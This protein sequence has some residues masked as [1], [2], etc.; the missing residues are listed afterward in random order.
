MKQFSSSWFSGPL[1]TAVIKTSSKEQEGS[2]R[3]IKTSISSIGGSNS[4]GMPLTSSST[5]DNFQ[6]RKA[7]NV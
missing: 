6:K 4:V 1:V 5:S 2:D 7:D 3:D